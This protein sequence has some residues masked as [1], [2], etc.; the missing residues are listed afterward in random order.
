[1][2]KKKDRSGSMLE[3]KG[4]KEGKGREEIGMFMCGRGDGGMKCNVE[5]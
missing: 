1:M 3:N 2:W 4:K 5:E